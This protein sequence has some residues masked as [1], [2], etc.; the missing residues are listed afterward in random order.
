MAQ[1]NIN[2]GTSAN[3]GTGD[4]LRDSQIKAN[5]NFTELYTNKV[6]KIA[7]KGLSENDFTDA[8]QTKLAGI[9]AGAEVNVQADFLQD[10]DTADDYIKNKP[11]SLYA[12]VG[13]FHYADAATKI[14]PILLTASVEQKLTNDT[15]GEYTN[16]S[17]APYTVGSV[18]DASIN[19][20]D[21]SQMSVG[22]TIDL[23]ID[24]TLETFTNNTDYSVVLRIGEDS[25]F[26]YELLVAEG[27]F[28]TASKQSVIGSVSF[29]L[30]YIEHLQNPASIYITVDNGSEVSVN[31][32]YPRIIL[33][34]VNI[35]NFDDSLLKRKSESL[36]VN[37]LLLMGSDVSIDLLID[38]TSY[39]DF[40]NSGL[41]SLV[42]FETTSLDLAPSPQYPYE[43]KDFVIRN[44]TG[45]SI[46]LKDN[47]EFAQIPFKLKGAINVVMPNDSA[48]WFKLVNGI[49]EAEEIMRSFG[50][51]IG[52]SSWGGITG[53]LADQID[54]QDALDAKLDKVETLDAER[55]FYAVDTDG[56]QIVVDESDV[57]PDLTGYAT[58]QWVLANTLK[59]IFL[60]SV[61]PT[62][63]PAS[64]P[65][66]A[67][68]IA[69]QS[70]TYTNFGGVVVDANSFAFISRS[71]TGVFSISQSPIEIKNFETWKQENYNEDSLVIE[72]DIVYRSIKPTSSTDIPNFDSVFWEPIPVDGSKYV[73]ENPIVF[74]D[75][76]LGKKF[77]TSGALVD[78]AL[79]FVTN[80]IPLDLRTI[81]LF[82]ASFGTFVLK[83]NF[84]DSSKNWLSE[85]TQFNDIR[86]TN[87]LVAFFRCDLL[88]S[89][90]LST[91]QSFINKIYTTETGVKPT[92]PIF[93]DI[94]A[95]NVYLKNRLIK[96][97]NGD[98]LY[99]YL[100]MTDAV[101]NKSD[102]I[103]VVENEHYSKNNQ[104]GVEWY[105]SSEVLISSVTTGLNVK[106][107]IGAVKC[108]LNFLNINNDLFSNVYFKKGYAINPDKLSKKFKQYDL[109][110]LVKPIINK[111]WCHIGDS[112]S[113]DLGDY[114]NY[115]YYVQEKLNFLN[116]KNTAVSG[117]T[118]TDFAVGDTYYKVT[119]TDDIVTIALGANDQGF[120][121]SIGVYGDNV[122]TTFYGTMNILY[123]RIRTTN[124][125][126]VIAFITLIRRANGANS[127]GLTV[128]EYRNAIIDFCTKKGIKF[129]DIY[130]ESGIDPNDATSLS[131][132]FSGDNTHPN[133][134]AHEKMIAPLVTEFVKKLI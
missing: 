25:D 20:F 44:S 21:F 52:S 54:L 101:A 112:I 49:A 93:G 95:S 100:T 26:E 10:D 62:S 39:Y 13:Y 73:S 58:E 108:K 119:P 117:R 115:P 42:G 45:N 96:K 40:Q 18:W 36:K 114:T 79:R 69:T 29:S 80:Y 72:S 43:G 63:T 109:G 92:T 60:G 11:D 22:D 3:D 131:T 65:T 85:S 86:T 118:M 78:D 81:Y 89:D 30:D 67:F 56:S 16:I 122:S 125:T 47:Y 5:S 133:S 87:P 129:L 107:P 33:K 12:S 19:S 8:E 116:F 23:R 88:I 127:L 124:P 24:L 120:N 34:N 94:S 111:S 84:Y 126:C 53:T 7:G 71:A 77:G 113:I 103:N 130:N 99:D 17:Q 27:S 57:A 9:E 121:K 31:G 68:W 64:T 6:D 134:L 102:F 55:R 104:L 4:T 48:I 1:Q 132:W 50:S 66:E 46:T 75:I 2:V 91:N 28:K 90:Y 41:V 37:D 51:G 110:D 38:G 83:V 61:T 128:L 123:D 35:I 14:T 105:N 97:I 98:N 106:A 32:W 74:K 76:I 82:N 15:L 59:G 70:G